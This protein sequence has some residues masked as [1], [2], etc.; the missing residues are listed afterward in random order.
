M[1][2][3]GE[4]GVCGDLKRGSGCRFG[5]GRWRGCSDLDVRTR[6]PRR[7]AVEGGERDW[8]AGLAE[9]RH[10]RASAQRATAP[11]R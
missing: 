8:Q 6:G 5:A 10:R 1:S 4:V 2:K 11:T 3:A 9:Q 7:R